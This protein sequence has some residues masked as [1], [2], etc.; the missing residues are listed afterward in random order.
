M[1]KQSLAFAMKAESIG[2]MLQVHRPRLTPSSILDLTSTELGPGTRAL[3][4]D[5]IKPL[6]DIIVDPFAV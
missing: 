5:I 2:E 1:E 6:A 4:V 3:Y